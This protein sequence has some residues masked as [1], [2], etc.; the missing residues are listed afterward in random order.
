MDSHHL[1]PVKCPGPRVLAFLQGLLDNRKS[2][3]M[4]KVY[5]AVSAVCHGTV[6]EV[7]LGAHNFLEV[8]KA[9]SPPQNP[10]VGSHSCIGV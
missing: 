2:P 5:T 10:G 4:L 9:T 8:S 7:S 1:H 6:D 3:S